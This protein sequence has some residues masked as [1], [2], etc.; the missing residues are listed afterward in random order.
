LNR[1]FK[2]FSALAAHFEA[3]ATRLPAAEHK[4]LEEIGKTVEQKAKAKIGTE[5]PGWAPL[6]E[7]TLADKGR[8]G[9]PVPAP[10]LRAGELRDS[11]SHEV[12]GNQV[13]IGSPSLLA[14]WQELGT[15]R[16]IPPRSF[17]GA[18]MIES[19]RQ[20]AATVLQW[21]MRAFRGR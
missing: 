5:Q 9:Y 17:L 6:A 12:E 11:I 14:L 3:V 19:K 15:S 1:E 8:Q 16:G 21:I 2:S 4:A 20:N 7:S 13:A 18:S 10:L